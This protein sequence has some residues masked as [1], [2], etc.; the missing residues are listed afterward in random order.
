MAIIVASALAR[1]AAAA[2]VGF[3]YGESYYLESARALA[4]SYYD[5][6]PL[7]LWIAH[8]VYGPFSGQTWSA[9][10]PFI[11]IFA[12]AG[13]GMYRLTARLYG[14][15]AGVWAVAF[16]NV[17][18]LFAISVGAWVQPDAPL[19]L[20]LALAAIPIA[21]LAFGQTPR[22]GLAWAAA[23][24]A[25]GLAALSKYHAALILAGLMLF[26]VTTP[27][28]RAWFFKPGLAIAAA[29]AAAVFAP[30]LLWNLQ[31][32]WLSFGFQSGRIG[33]Y[34][35]L[36]VDWLARDVLGQA[37]QIGVFVWPLLMFV[38]YRALKRGPAEPKDWWLACLAA[39]PIL[40][41]TVASA[42]AP[43]GYHFHWQSP[44][45][46][47]LFP[48]LGKAADEG[49]VQ[50]RKW[51]I[52]AAAFIGLFLALIASQTSTGW[53]SHL[54]HAWNPRADYGATNPTRELLDWRPLRE[55]LDKR[56][57]LTREKLFVATGRWFF[58]GKADAAI[59]DKLPVVC[60]CDDPRNIAFVSDDKTFLGW[61]ALILAP[62]FKRSD[63]VVDYRDYFGSIERLPDIEI[64]LG[65]ETAETIHVFLAHGYVKPYPMPYGLTRQ[66]AGRSGG[67]A[68]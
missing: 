56:G 39:P 21:D 37:F 43:F 60:L 41:F 16:L 27:G 19:F 4:L 50:A 42:W 25:F 15:R 18:P 6:P 66:T 53:V 13:W 8:F 47:F 31:T 23:G 24:L 35:G 68:P 32:H 22:P 7:A 11:V 58:A 29:L 44:G 33:D 48:L 54:L 10:L 14:E 20:F 17:S 51:L 61:D 63:P 36:H 9:R 45:Y 34:R 49:A 40:L 46:F 2:V 5:Q 55:A 67:E 62:T 28:Y 65:G 12:L 1:L 26:V 57:L 38:F 30:V 64:P 59:G 3:G 52:A